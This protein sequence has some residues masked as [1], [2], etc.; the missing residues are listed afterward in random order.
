MGQYRPT[1]SDSIVPTTECAKCESQGEVNG[2][3]TVL[4]SSSAVGVR[5]DVNS[6]RINGTLSFAP[7]RTWSSLVL[8]LYCPLIS[9]YGYKRGK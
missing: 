8:T 4:Q 5:R 7:M 3:V 9:L 2:E 1:T 6:F